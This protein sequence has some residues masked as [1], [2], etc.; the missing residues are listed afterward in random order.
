MKAIKHILVVMDPMREQQPALTRAI[1]LAK[2]TSANIELFL[3]VYNKQLV[4]HWTFDAEQLALLRKDY[5]SSKLRWLET[6]VNE[7]VE[8]GLM[9]K[10]DIKWH[11]NIAT[12]VLDKAEQV[13]A[14]IVIKSTHQHPTLNKLFFTPT[15]W[16]L[17]QQ[18]HKPL[19]L[20]KSPT[21]TLSNHVEQTSNYKVIMAAV[22]PAKAHD[23]PAG[24]GKVIIDASA[25]LAALFEANI[26]VSH[27]YQPVG[28]EMWQ[29]MSSVGMDQS[30]PMMDFKEYQQSIEDYHQ[31]L[32]DELVDDYGFEYSSLHLVSGEVEFELAELVQKK[33]VDLLVVGM[34]D[35]VGFTGNTVE[36]ILDNVHCDI[37]SV[38]VQS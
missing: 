25:G 29:G 11:K 8:Q 16:R 31:K 38:K 37:L 6:Y 15:D 3:V 32:F 14:D 30:L 10:L 27:C 36:K 9:V 5:L 20:V 4:S 22:D 18:C 33:Q 24:L 2:L 17:L 7:V 23:K 1:S 28:I 19:L 34:G 35:N 21:D 26:H 13:S 12:A